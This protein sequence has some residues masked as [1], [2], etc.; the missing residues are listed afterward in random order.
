MRRHLGIETQR[1][2]SDL[3]ILRTTPVLLGLFSGAT[4]MAD[5]L[6]GEEGKLRVSEAAWYRKEVAT[7]SDA[8]AAVRRSLWKRRDN[9]RS[10]PETSAPK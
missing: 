6:A 1:Q 5:E 10:G 9:G 3:A 8:L 2:W 4:L 7:F